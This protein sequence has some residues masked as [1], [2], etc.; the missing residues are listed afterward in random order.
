MSMSNYS[1]PNY[2][3]SCQYLLNLSK[4]LAVLL[5]FDLFIEKKRFK[6]CVRGAYKKAHINELLRGKYS[7]LPEEVS[8]EGN[9]SWASDKLAEG[10]TGFRHKQR[11]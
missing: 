3:L 9:I 8:V 7:N 4:H 11:G 6:C 5:T 2:F 10:N 1:F